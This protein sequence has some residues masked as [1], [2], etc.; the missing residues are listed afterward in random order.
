MSRMLTV[1]PNWKTPVIERLQWRTDV[2]KPR[3]GA[4]QRISLRRHPMA[5]V[6]YDFLA[7]SDELRVFSTELAGGQGSVWD[8]PLW[9]QAQ[10]LQQPASAGDQVIPLDS[11]DKYGIFPGDRVAIFLTREH[12]EVVEVNLTSSDNITLLSVL[13]NNWPIGALV[14]PLQQGYLHDRIRLD[15]ITRETASGVI[16]C[17]LVDYTSKPYTNPKDLNGKILLD[18]QPNQVTPLQNQLSRSMATFDHDTGTPVFYDLYGFSDSVQVLEFVSLRRD[19]VGT[20]RALAEEC[21]GR[22]KSFYMPSHKA[23]LELHSSAVST[24][25]FLSIKNVGYALNIFPRFSNQYIRAFKTDGSHLDLQIIGAS[26]I[27]N[28][29]EQITLSTTI[30]EDLTIEG[31]SHISFIDLYRFDSDSLEI[32]WKNRASASTA[33]TVRRVLQ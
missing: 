3:S 16:H 1:Q 30:G 27:D 9:H 5:T 15:T 31:V 19:G 7:H 26:I 22:W 25:G 23:D 21:R 12:Y 4:E 6:E 17:T 33:I 29:V 13:S 8:I 11:V 10:E 24:Q 32:V 28:E 18:E 2:L 14:V 20:I